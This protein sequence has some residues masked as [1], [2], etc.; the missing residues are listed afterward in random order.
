LAVSVA[1]E[2]IRSLEA[3][4]K[5]LVKIQNELT[6]AIGEKEKRKILFIMIRIHN[7]NR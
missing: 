7:R 3:N 2:Y 6:H 5:K 1:L 4:T